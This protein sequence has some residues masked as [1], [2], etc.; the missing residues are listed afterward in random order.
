MPVIYNCSY[1]V[2]LER[3]NNKASIQFVMMSFIMKLSAE[4]ISRIPPPA[5][6]EWI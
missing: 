4:R 1:T 6:L 2:T 5:L 3:R